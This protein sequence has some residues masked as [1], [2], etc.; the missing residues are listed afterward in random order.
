MQFVAAVRLH[1]PVSV[2]QLHVAVVANPLLGAGPDAMN[3]KEFKGQDAPH[4]CSIM[5]A[6]IA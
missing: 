2:M 6:S 4:L 3:S 1:A 5:P